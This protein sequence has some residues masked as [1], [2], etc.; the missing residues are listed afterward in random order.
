M[1][2]ILAFL[3]IAAAWPTIR[4]QQWVGGL[5][6]PVDLKSP[7][8]GSGR[9]FAL[10][11]PGRVRVIRNGVLA[12]TPV[13]DIVSKVQYKDEMGLL[14]IA[15]PP[16]FREK[17][18]FYL[19]Y[20]DKQRRTIVARY[21][22]SGDTADPASEEVLLTIAQPYENHNG[23]CLQFGPRDGLL[24][25]GMGDGGSAGDPQKRAQ[26]P[27]SMLGK[28]LRMDV[29]NGSRTAEV[30]AL[31]LR[32]PWRFSFDRATGDLFIGDVGQND[33][34]EID[35]QPANATRGLNYGWSLMEGTRCYDDRNCA[36][37]TDLVA[38][39]FGYG[40][41]DGVSVTGGYIYRGPAYP[42]M[43]GIYIFGDYG[44]GQIFGLRRNGAAWETTKLVNPELPVVS[45]AEDEA[46]ELYLVSHNGN[47]LRMTAEAPAQGVNAIVSG[48]S[49]LPGIAA[50]GIATAFVNGLAG[51]SGI[52]AAE[53]Y[54]LPAALSGVTVRING[55]TVPLYAVANSGVGAQV[56]FQVPWS[57]IG[58][59]TV[60][61]NGAESRVN[62]ASVA[63]A[64]FT[65]DGRRAAIRGNAARDG[66][67]EIYATGLGAVSNSPATGTAAPV[68]PLATV[69]EQ[70]E[71]FIGGRSAQV[72]FAGLAPGF[73][74]LYQV[75][76]VVP[77]ETPPGEAEL[78]LRTGG[79]ASG[80]V[81]LLI[82]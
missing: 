62:V 16:G 54:P 69:V 10:E 21:R 35:F 14:G 44:S 49:F 41:N 42:F 19:N 56:N 64:V 57:V 30:W 68:S 58:D 9:M 78:T 22:M 65:V 23:G 67:I 77:L 3:L 1:G 37:R 53:R 15:F 82:Q 6:A 72:L 17:Q 43:Q 26:N 46:G 61:V 20:V 18:Y 66:A 60:A 39:I 33:M 7:M 4:W 48:A 73:A 36:S 71:V 27:N 5:E 28:M 75:N 32:N 31:G 70:V 12:T 51:V 59:A 8:D 47:L 76:A 52:V 2:S 55:Q 50:G 40:R 24:Y 63:P 38:P 25:I 29:E 13:L 81:R 45:F 80:T 11:Q 74:G 79:I 34:E